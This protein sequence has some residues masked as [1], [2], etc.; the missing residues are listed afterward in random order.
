VNNEKSK[1]LSVTEIITRLQ[2]WNTAC[3]KKKTSTQA[4]RPIARELI[5]FVASEPVRVKPTKV[6]YDPMSA[7]W[8]AQLTASAFNRLR[9][10]FVNSYCSRGAHHLSS[11][12]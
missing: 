9:Q 6:A 12:H 7:A 4:A 3:S 11:P 10:N 8:Q 2:H 1:K 5:Y